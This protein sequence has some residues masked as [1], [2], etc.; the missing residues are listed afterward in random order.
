MMARGLNSPLTSSCGRLFDAVAAALG[1]CRETIAYEG[2]AAI[3]LETLAVRAG[4]PLAAGEGYGFGLIQDGDRWLLDPAPMW[5]EL[6][7]ALARGEDGGLIAARFH[8]GLAL[9]MADLAAR[10][11]AQRGL[12]TLAL[13]GGV[14]GSEA[15]TAD[16]LRAGLQVV[17]LARGIQTLSSCFLML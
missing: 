4:R 2:Q 12:D 16:V 8:Q 3:E 11:A 15:A 10:L 9:A 13:S 6:L 5:V 7:A 14:L 17:G 1:L